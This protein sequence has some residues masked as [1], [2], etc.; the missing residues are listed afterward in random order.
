[1]I[2]SIVPLIVGPPRHIRK[3]R[4][5]ESDGADSSEGGSGEVSRDIKVSNRVIFEEDR[6]KGSAPD[7]KDTISEKIDEGVATEVHKTEVK[8]EA[9]NAENAED[10]V[11]VELTTSAHQAGLEDRL[12]R[13]QAENVRLVRKRRD[14]LLRHH[15]LWSVYEYGLERISRL[16]D[17]RDAP[18]AVLPGNFPTIKLD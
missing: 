17:L 13:L 7:R 15:D 18:D 2:S 16:N 6:A 5:E 8:V 1:M 3:R 10:E 14:V 4:R 9:E 12:R 11:P